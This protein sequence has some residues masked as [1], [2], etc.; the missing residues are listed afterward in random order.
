MHVLQLSLDVLQ[1][2]AKLP[3]QH[4]HLLGHP[5]HQFGDGLIGEDA[6]LDLLDDEPLHLLRVQVARVA[7]AGAFL[8][9]GAADVVGVAPAFRPL[10]GVGLAA[11]PAAQEAAQQELAPHPCR[12][13]PLRRPLLER[14]LHPVEQVPG[15]DR[16]PGTLRTHG[17]G[18]LIALAGTTPDGG[19]RI[20]LVG[21]QVVEAVPVPAPAPVGDAALVQVAADLL[22]AGAPQRAL[23]HL[24]HDRGGD[25][26]D[27][28][29]GT[30]PHAVADL[31]APVA[32]GRPGREEVAARGGLAHAARD[33]LGKILRIKF[34]DALDDGFHQLAGRGVVGVLG[35]GDDAD[36]APAEHRLEG[37]G[38]L[39][40][41]REARELP[42]EDLLEGRVGVAGRVQHL[43]EL[44]PV[45]D[46]AALGLVHVLAGDGVAVLLGVVPQRPQLGGDGEV[47]VLTVA[48][49]AGVEGGGL[50]GC[51]VLHG[52]VLSGRLGSPVVLQGATGQPEERSTDVRLARTLG[53]IP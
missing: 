42:D 15:H 44:G 43:A 45:G 36:A 53:R 16:L 7:R 19:S 12:P 14:P 28:E 3:R 11:D 27:L 52:G 1:L 2:S 48:G 8:E 21:E 34:I 26:V 47:D 13:L 5:R 29:G 9:Q 20:G 39:P 31:H 37:D 24:A 23:E 49:D 35:D 25:R 46:A 38:V 22:E 18:R 6:V 30:L 10:A 4:I 33:L 32:E 51:K 41:A 40:L 50:G 17:F